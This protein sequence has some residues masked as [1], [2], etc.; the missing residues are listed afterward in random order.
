MSKRRKR[1]DGKE[2]V[3]RELPMDEGKG[4]SPKGYQY[5]CSDLSERL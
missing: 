4:E 1:C 5:I 2:G 3:W